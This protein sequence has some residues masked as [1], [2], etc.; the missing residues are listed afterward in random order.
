MPAGHAAALGF[1]RGHGLGA[2]ISATQRPR[3]GDGPPRAQARI[4]RMHYVI[5]IATAPRPAPATHRL[6]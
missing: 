1:Q 5:V 4:D 2:A 3:G 6:A